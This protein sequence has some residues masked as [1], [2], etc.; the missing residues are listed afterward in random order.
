MKT[1]FIVFLSLLLPNVSAAREYDHHIY[2]YNVVPADTVIERE[3]TG[4]ALGIAMGQGQCDLSSDKWQ[5]SVGAGYFDGAEAYAAG[6]CKGYGG[7]TLNVKIGRES[8]KTGYG[9]G[10]SW[11]F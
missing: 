7:A 4:T 5:A 8:D 6:L 2:N 11:K 1:L 3:T 9:I 10:T